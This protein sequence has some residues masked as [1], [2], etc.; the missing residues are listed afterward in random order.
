MGT[1]ADDRCPA[2]RI[3]RH[4]EDNEVTEL[5]GARPCEGSVLRVSIVML[6]LAAHTL[7]FLV[8]S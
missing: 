3:H 5:I 7:S 4:R 6:E 8:I 1:A 2:L